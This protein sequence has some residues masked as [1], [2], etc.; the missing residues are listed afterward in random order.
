[1]QNL[2]KVSKTKINST[3]EEKEAQLKKEEIEQAESPDSED[4]NE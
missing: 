4:A 3:L 1:M 2:K